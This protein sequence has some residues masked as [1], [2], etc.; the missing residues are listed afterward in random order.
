MKFSKFKTDKGAESEG[1]WVDL[2]E[3][4]RLK[5]ARLSNPKAANYLDDLRRPYL[6]AY[7]DGN[8]PLDTAKKF[9]I[10]TVAKYVLMDW[11]GLTEDD[12]KTHIVYSE[13]KA[14]ELLESSDD[15]LNTVVGLAGD[16]DLFLE[17]MQEEGRKNS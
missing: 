13:E 17:E 16:R 12:E 15:F 6:R 14:L 11:D 5:I 1:V 7:R 4:L 2:P 9:I 10:K 8:L 3:G